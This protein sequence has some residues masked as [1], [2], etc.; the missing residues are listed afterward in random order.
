M[1]MQLLQF[2][3]PVMLQYQHIMLESKE[4]FVNSL[5]F[6]M[7]FYSATS[8]ESV[9]DQVVIIYARLTE[10][11]V[12]KSLLPCFDIDLLLLCNNTVI[13]AITLIPLIK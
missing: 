4:E 6:N 2:Y 8:M 1:I 5:L 13:F 12:A 3:I 11:R 9:L 10:C 7:I